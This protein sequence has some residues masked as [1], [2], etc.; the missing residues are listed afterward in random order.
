MFSNYL[1]GLREGLEASLVVCILIAYLVKTGNKDKLAP[2]WLGVGLAAALSL[3]F[4][5]GLEFGTQELT[6]KAQEA[7]GGTLSIV[8]VGLVTWMVFWMKRTARHLKAELHG[9]LDAALA[10]GTGALVATAFLAVGREGLE[11][12]LFVWR[13]VHAAGDGAGPL[14]GVLLGIGSSILLGWLF[15]RGALKIN[16]SKF[17]TWTGAMLVVVAAGVLAYGVHDLQEADFL[18]GLTDKAFDVSSAIPPDSWYGT[19]L[20]GTLNFQP[21]PTV[22]QVIVWALYLVPVLALFLAP[23]LVKRSKPEAAESAPSEPRSS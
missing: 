3:A 9:K 15:Y 12:S 1:I 20:K 14:I 2:L 5:A 22:L 13:S 8:A 17:F 23:S 11:T 4:G 7:I 21:D 18:P 10:M 6:F 19:L 16:L